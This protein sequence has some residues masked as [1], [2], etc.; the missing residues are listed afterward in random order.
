MKSAGVIALLLFCTGGLLPAQDAATLEFLKAE[1]QRTARQRDEA[2]KRLLET[3]SLSADKVKILSEEQQHLRQRLNLTAKS[4]LELEAA[5]R[6]S[7]VAIERSETE[8]QAKES[9]LQTLRGEQEA[10]AREF[11]KV[12]A[13][14]NA[15]LA[16]AQAQALTDAGSE[17]GDL[18]A[19]REQLRQDLQDR[20][21][22]LR[23]LETARQQ[24]LNAL[25]DLQE[26]NRQLTGDLESSRRA[27][28]LANAKL[29]A[30]ESRLGGLQQELAEQY[31]LRSELEQEKEKLE[32]TLGELQNRLR[33]MESGFAQVQKERDLLQA[34][35]KT[36]STKV[37]TLEKKL[38]ET[39]GQNRVL[40]Q[41]NEFL[42]R[43]LNDERRIRSR[44]EKDIADLRDTMQKAKDAGIEEADLETV[45]LLVAEMEREKEA[46]REEALQ[47]RKN[48][49]ALQAQLDDQSGT[50]QMQIREMQNMLVI[51][52]EEIS[53]AQKKIQHL[54]ARSASLDDVR[55][56]KDRLVKLQDKS[57]EDMRTLA[58]HI[59]ELRDELV[60][61]KET[62]R[63]AL[64]AIQ[65]NQEL[66][67]EMDLLR[68]EMEKL[69]R[70]NQA[71]QH[72]DDAK[73]D[74]I[75][76]LRQELETKRAQSEAAEREKREL[77]LQLQ[78]VQRTS[79]GTP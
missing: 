63:K 48:V 78:E 39:E 71:L 31:R 50:Q 13:E 32:N 62:Q 28:S 77:L 4:L 70:L 14:L 25:R 68:Q 61:S 46:F 38:E 34:K 74:R 59:Y 7:Q 72:V 33:E 75:F 10:A 24:D 8:L 17:A 65:K 12:T 51:Q 52:L 30:L 55:A 21:L 20:E 53:A 15:K 73:E 1:I 6:M 3:E 45:A 23:Q 49:D 40:S 56:Q 19:E 76:E 57:R 44:M 36:L 66:A 26:M 67:K 35:G 42:Q 43:Q 54:E 41:Q 22:Q 60:K 58:G 9:A 27:E 79:T 64:L 47:H 11:E 18:A 5:A 37:E 2:R 29:S 69:K 16:A